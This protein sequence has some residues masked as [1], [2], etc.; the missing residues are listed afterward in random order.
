MDAELSWLKTPWSI[1]G[2]LRKEERAWASANKIRCQHRPAAIER[3][4]LF[5]GEHPFRLALSLLL[6]QGVLLCLAD[7]VPP[8]WIAPLWA[9]WNTEEHLAYFSAVWGIQTTLVA[10]VYPIVIAFVAVFLQ[11]RPTSEAFIS[12]Y[13]LDS[14]GL[15]AGLSSLA[16]VLVMTVQYLMVAT[17]GVEALAAWT[18]L[19]TGWLVL[20]AALTTFFLYRTVEFLRPEVQAR[21]I[22][23]YLVNVALPREVARLNGFQVFAA[24]MRGLPVNLYGED[25][26]PEGPR[27][28]VGTTSFRKGKAEVSKRVTE[29]SMLLDLRLWLV[30]LVVWSWSRRALTHPRPERNAPLGRDRLW[31]LL[32]LPMKPGLVFNA[33]LT[34][35]QVV[36]GPSL[37][38]W[39]KLLLLL[40]VK[41]GAESGQRPGILVESVLNEMSQ[42]ARQAAASGDSDRF[43]RAYSVLLETHRLL[44]GASLVLD[45]HGNPSSWALLPDVNSFFNRRLH[46]K[47]AESYRALF[48]AAV[49]NLA[50]NPQPLLRLCYLPMHLSGE[51]LDSSPPEIREHLLQFQPVLMYLLGRWWARRAGEQGIR[52]LEPNFSVVLAAPLQSQ[53]DEVL[54]KFV[55]GWENGRPDLPTR[56]HDDDELNWS[57]AQQRS[58]LSVVHLEETAWMLLSAVYRGDRAAAEWFADVLSK[59]WDRLDYNVEP[60][61]LYK[62]SDFITL[63]HLGLSWNDFSDLF[64][65]QAEEVPG[66]R[67]VQL[68]LQKAVYRAA[69]RNFWADVRLLVVELLVDWGRRAS[70]SDFERSLA[71]GISSGLLAGRQWRDGD[72]LADSLETLTAADYLGAKVRQFAASGEWR[73][74][75][76][77]RLDSFVERSKRM[78]RP[79]MVSSRI[80]SF[81]G[82]DNVESLQESQL[83]V[84]AVLTSETWSMSRAFGEQV[85]LWM[86]AQYNS[87]SILLHRLESWLTR[88]NELRGAVPPIVQFLRVKS[89][90]AAKLDANWEVVADALS[91]VKADIDTARGEAL[92]AEPIDPERLSA[93]ARFASAKGFSRE[94]AEFPV[95]LFDI[96]GRADVL[97]PYTL[98]LQKVRKGELTRVE[99]DQRAINEDEAFA[100]M[101][102]Q[103]VASV[104]LSDVLRQS[105]VET[106]TVLDAEAYWLALQ[107]RSAVIESHGDAAIL[108]LD[109]ATRPD[110]IWD[111]QHEGYESKYSRPEGLQVQRR[112]G[113]GHGYV[114]HFNEVA[115]YVA[116]LPYGQSLLLPLNALKRLEFTEFSAGCYVRPEVVS[117]RETNSLVDLNLT[118]A[119]RV[120]V[121][122]LNVLRLVYRPLDAE[123]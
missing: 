90:P 20:N 70:E 113:Y 103:R 50:I 7:R 81:S 47:W 37:T 122:D 82:A 116:P 13:L 8:E 36:D 44:L 28:L 42:E 84:L 117:L 102:S 3:E 56:R 61:Q 120:H 93:I 74:G 89:R 123:A 58:K 121:S 39:E 101:L 32:V 118:F 76:V 86:R 88:L 119:R 59:W 91:K 100:E 10:L 51:E 53:Y 109:N 105:H 94:T 65:L 54:A 16:L 111:W 24:S 33:S 55:G 64:G 68:E 34:L 23:R 104:V 49:E 96:E 43:E 77:G 31:P 75:Y 6:L 63:D 107:N 110:W 72:G 73:G 48:E 60:F 95:Q 80:Y 79:D 98:R 66:V 5:A 25:D 71:L 45:D 21:V 92:A 26:P 57:L 41:V 99:L 108:M 2:A 46:E 29:P 87:V 11:R 85:N 35:A 112:D 14:G 4:L 114:C 67:G 19:N 97:E 22:R 30:R 12:I 18:V 52:S 15:A 38:R 78:E 62:K 17:R 1:R 40:A 106:E 27:L 69:L 83:Y 115:V 9:D